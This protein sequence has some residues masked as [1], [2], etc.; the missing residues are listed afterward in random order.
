[1]TTELILNSPISVW[2]ATYEQARADL[3]E[4]YNT[5]KALQ[6][7][8]CILTGEHFHVANHE[9]GDE[10]ARL[11][12][13]CWAGLIKASGVRHVMSPR[14]IEVMDDRLYN[15]HRHQP[16]SEEMPDFTEANVLN[17]LQAF[18]ASIGDFFADYCRE[19]FDRFYPRWNNEYKTNER[20]RIKI[21]ERVILTGCVECDARFDIASLHPGCP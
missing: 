5:R 2:V 14:A 11:K 16:G 19:V 7:R 8:I 12:R 9:Y 3:I 6:E 17:Q 18:R 1:M 10:L 4:T 15:R 13:D 21:G 20:N